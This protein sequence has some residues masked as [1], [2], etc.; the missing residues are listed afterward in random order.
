[1]KVDPER[2]YVR[3]D[4]NRPFGRV[5]GHLGAMYEQ[6]GKLFDA[7]GEPLVKEVPIVELPNTLHLPKKE[8]RR[9]DLERK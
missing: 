3:L 9:N 4:T 6:D 7:K 5:I 1:M 8:I 2:P